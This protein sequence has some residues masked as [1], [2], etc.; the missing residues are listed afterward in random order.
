MNR[1][2]QIA[3]K[4][5]ETEADALL[6]TSEANRFYATGFPSTDGAVLVTKKKHYYFTDSRYIEAARATISDAKIVLIR[7]GNDYKAAIN[8]AVKEC[9]VKKLGFEEKSMSVSTWRIYAQAVQAEFVPAQDLTGKMR[10]AKD[11]SE[12][13]AITKGAEDRRA[14]I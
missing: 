6:L 5:S 1:F 2:T 10:A 9:G 3:K 11:E 7:R 8:D 14:G 13:E 12:I 4:L